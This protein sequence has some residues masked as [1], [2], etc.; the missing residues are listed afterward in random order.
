MLTVD[1]FLERSDGKAE[2]YNQFR[3]IADR[4]IT[5][6]LTLCIPDT[7]MIN[8]HIND[9]FFDNHPENELR[10]IDF[11][12]FL[13]ALKE[14]E[15]EDLEI[16]QL[17][18][19]FDLWEE[20]ISMDLIENAYRK[21]LD[22]LAELTPVYILGNHDFPLID[23][24]DTFGR[25]LRHFSKVGAELTTIYEHGFQP[26]ILNN[27]MRWPGIFGEAITR[28]SGIL[29]YLNPDIDFVARS[30][31]KW[32]R[33]L[34]RTYH[35]GPTPAKNPEKFSYHEYFNFYIDLMKKYNAKNRG[36]PTDLTL[37]V[38][39]H[40][41]AARLVSRTE[42]GKRYHFMDCG[43]WVYGGSEFGIISGREMAIC[44]WHL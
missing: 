38:I 23:G 21:L 7:H 36:E 39:G 28:L 1:A 37:A 32:M 25:I 27:P 15:K 33:E 11:L 8:K 30:A 14:A 35:E 29:E 6:K 13:V 3:A 22:L 24:G 10:L 26:D 19:L 18:D 16:I 34:L 9:D 41:H 40:T 43:S 5:G 42:G 4:D 20:R 12:E 31:W 17:G 44:Q 2:V